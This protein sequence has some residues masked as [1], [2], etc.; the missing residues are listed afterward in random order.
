MARGRYS[1]NEN[2]I[3][4]FIKEGRGKGFG[5]SY[6]PWL[7]IQ[8]VPSHGRSSRIQG[9][10]TERMHHFLSD[11][12]KHY[13]YLLEWSDI[14]LDIR[15]QYPLLEREI[16]QQIAADAGIEHP[17]DK[18]TQT[19]LVFTTDFLISIVVNG[20]IVELART[21]KPA[22]ELDN[23]RTIEKFEIERRYWTAKGI[24]WGIVTEKEIPNNLVSNIESIHKSFWIEGELDLPQQEIIY[25]AER[26]KEGLCQNELTITQV[27]SKLDEEINASGAKSLKVFKHLLARK[28]VAVDVMNPLDFFK[29]IKSL[30]LS[31]P[32]ENYLEKVG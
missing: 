25:I 11:H 15:E 5:K 20:K 6:K 7:K 9:W 19:P 22:V 17:K 21:I 30:N 27:T 2:K 31:F 16:V 1:W 12:E 3:Q 13:F 29:P 10:K 32:N 4:K 14:V 28:E 23:P 8:D 18:E 26:L 24:N